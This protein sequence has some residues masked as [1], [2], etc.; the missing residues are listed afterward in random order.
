MAVWHRTR[1][2]QRGTTDGIEWAVCPAP[3][4]GV[5][6]GYARLPDTHPWRR[7]DRDDIPVETHGELTYGPDEEG[8]IGFDTLHLGDVWPGVWPRHAVTDPEECQTVWSVDRV[9]AAAQHLARQ[10]AMSYGAVM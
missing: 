6:N 1:A 5:Y 2:V 10:V 7:L 9:A 3:V 8:W 4:A